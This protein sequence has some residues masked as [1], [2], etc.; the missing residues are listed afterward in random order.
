MKE[1]WVLEID[2]IG[3]KEAFELQKKIVRA[4]SKDEIKDMFI[5]LE[6]FPVFTANRKETFNNILASEE[7]LEKEGIEICRT[8]RGGDVTYHGP[9]QVVGYNIM[10]LKVRLKIRTD[11]DL[12][13]RSGG[14]NA[15]YMKGVSGFLRFLNGR[16]S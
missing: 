14:G 16:L 4:R 2:K 5:L 1:G 8:D 15:R 11:R 10:D 7:L 9:G 6:H 12:P 3:Y 13:A